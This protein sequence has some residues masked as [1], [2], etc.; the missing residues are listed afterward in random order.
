[1][2]HTYHQTAPDGKPCDPT[3]EAGMDHGGGAGGA[4]AVYCKAPRSLITWYYSMLDFIG[5]ALISGPN[6]TPQ[7][8]STGLQLYPA[9]HYGTSGPTPDPRPALVGAG[10]GKYGFL[11][12]ALE[13]RWRPDFTSPK[14]EDKAGWVE[15]PDCQRHYILWP[16]QYSPGWSPSDPAYNAWCGAPNGF[17][18]TEASDYR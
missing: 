10:A 8:L 11:V 16:N 9:T 6:L 5:G 17:P 3:S 14:P 4:V 1:M 7:H 18:K 2:Y 13:W 15:Y 12:D